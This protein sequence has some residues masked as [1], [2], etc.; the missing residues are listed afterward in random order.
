V[1]ETTLEVLL[2]TAAG[3]GFLHTVAG[4]DHYVP[5]V[6]MSRA[7][8]WSLPKTLVITVACGIGHV[9]S[10]VVLGLIGIA[11]GLAVARLT[12][13][14]GV[15]GSV[16]GWLLLGFGLAYMVWGIHRAVRNRPHTHWHT[17]ADGIAHH[18]SHVHSDAH[19]HVHP[20]QAKARSLTP[21]ILFTIFV[22]GPCEP[23]IPLVMYPAA[24][25]SWWGVALV[26]LIFGVITIGTM[27]A[28]VLTSSLGLARISL[29]RLERYTHALAGLAIAACGGAVLA[30][31]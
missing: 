14:E 15:R 7:G 31:F 4:P 22:F 18:H 12:W 23:L 1:E 21:W 11:A 6:A 25:Q 29:T 13:F 2:V 19:A 27:T 30:G 8:R 17:H 3:I 10:S 9:L 28:I 20:D 5:F 16:A 24:R 26:T